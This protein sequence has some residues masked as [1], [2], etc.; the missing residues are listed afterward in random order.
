MKGFLLF[1]MHSNILVPDKCLFTAG[2]K[3]RDSELILDINYVTIA[4]VQHW[5]TNGFTLIK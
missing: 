1:D 4:L 5:V 3:C 2:D